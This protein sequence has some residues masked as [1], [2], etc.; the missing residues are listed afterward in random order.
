[1]PCP[2]DSFVARLS[3]S[4]SALE[5]GT[6][7]G[8]KAGELNAGLSV[9]T[10]GAAYVAGTTRSTDYPTRNALQSQ[11]KGLECGPPPGA[12]CTDLYLT[13]L[14]SSG[15]LVYSTYLGGTK[16]DRAGGIAVD[17]QA[18][19]HL[20]GFTESAD[21][22]LAGPVQR[23][24]D[25][26]SCGTTEPLELCHDAIVTGVAAGGRSLA[27]STYL[28]ANAEDQGLGIDVADSGT[29]HVTGSTDSRE[30]RTEQP[31]QGELAGRIDTFVARLAPGGHDLV[32]STFLGG[33]EDE[34]FNG[35]AVDGKG[36]SLLAGRT[37]S[38]DFPTANP[39][40]GQLAGDIDGV[41]VKLR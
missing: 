25:N 10:A 26:S 21:F 36:A 22:P 37:T 38:T 9:D 6:Y 11:I 28:G 29:V 32:L 1:V 23:A 16:N 17:K 33:R 40:Q 4:G 34:R 3:A 19:A 24:L 7:L 5:Y 8:G 2:F 20:T 13:K 30:F 31:L 14:N 39:L 18:R 41:V 27:Y 12:P 15:G 35:I